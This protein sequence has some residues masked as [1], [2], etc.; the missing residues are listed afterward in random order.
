MNWWRSSGI[1]ILVLIALSLIPGV[2]RGQSECDGADD[3]FKEGKYEEALLVYNILLKENSNLECAQKGKNKAEAALHAQ[4]EQF[5]QL[6]KAYEAAGQ[7]ELAREAYINALKKNP[8]HENAQNTLTLITKDPFA[9]VRALID[10]GLFTSAAELLEE[11]VKE[12]PDVPVPEDLKYLTGGKVSW[13]R[14]VRRWIE[15]RLWS[16]SGLMETVAKVVAAVVIAVLAVLA[17]FRRILPWIRGS[18]A[19]RY[20]LNIEPFN[21][22]K[23]S[24]EIGGGLAAMVGE[25]FQQIK[26]QRDDPLLLDLVEGPITFEIPADMKLTT[27]PIKTISDLIEWAFPQKVITLLGCLQRAGDLG[28]GLTLKL[29]DNQTGKIMSTGT[30]WRADCDEKWQEDCNQK[31]TETPNNEDPTP[32][33]SLVKPA[34]IWI[35]FQLAKYEETKGGRTERIASKLGTEDWQSYVFFWT[36]LHSKLQGNDEDARKR[37]LKALNRDPKNRYALADLGYVELVKAIREK[38]PEEFEQALD[39]LERAKDITEKYEKGLE[40]LQWVKKII[41]S[42]QSEQKDKKEDKKEDKIHGDNTWYIA[43]YH[44]AA[45][46]SYKGDKKKAEETMEMLFETS[47]ETIN[48]LKKLQKD[49]DWV[50]NRFLKSMTWHMKKYL[51]KIG[52]LKKYLKGIE[53]IG[54]YLK[55][56]KIVQEYL[57]KMEPRI[58]I[59]YAIELVNVG[60]LEKANDLIEKIVENEPE[61]PCKRLYDLACYYSVLGEK[62]GKE[63]TNEYDKAL[64][65]MRYALLEGGRTVQVADLEPYLDGIRKEKQKEFTK[66][67]GRYDL[68]ARE[69]TS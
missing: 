8:T 48:A 5:Y 13:L 44:I 57:E 17:F 62:K 16:W 20:R 64:E 33:Y 3:L 7:L 55:D 18:F 45:V 68:E 67:I 34:A 69:L 54:E 6:G 60:K 2:T 59:E 36:G 40:W 65:Y 14:Q 38:K 52:P 66:L 53:P 56:I 12:N 51:E 46:Y 29:V 23:K 21:K 61:L 27:L 22:E 35:L 10:I 43:M 24:Q 25:E 19:H 32:Y 11:M 9:A 15:P 1:V 50:L 30:I 41:E 63:R 4:A 39:V 37:F 28:A 49:E 42:E 26:T 47:Q 58:A 31:R